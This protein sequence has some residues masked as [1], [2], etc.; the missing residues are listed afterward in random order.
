[1]AMVVDPLRSGL[2]DGWDPNGGFGAV[3][4]LGTSLDTSY[5]GDGVTSVDVDPGFEAANVSALDGTGRLIL[6]GNLGRTRHR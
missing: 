1:M 6:A 2:R 4:Y 3:R 5:S